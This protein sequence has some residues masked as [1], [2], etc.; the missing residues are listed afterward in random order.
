MRISA[1]CHN[2][3]ADRVVT[4]GAQTKLCE[5]PLARRHSRTQ[6][7]RSKNVVGCASI[8]AHC[9]LAAAISN[10]F[11]NASM[12]I[13]I[14]RFAFSTSEIRVTHRQISTNDKI[15]K[16]SHV[17]LMIHQPANLP[18]HSTVMLLCGPGNLLHG[19]GRAI[20]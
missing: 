6:E 1:P 9:S 12:S 11:R 10:R 16:G 7:Q 14:Q 20:P 15:Q 5:Q 4:F 17:P 18:S 8:S 19:E 3:V 2:V 13:H